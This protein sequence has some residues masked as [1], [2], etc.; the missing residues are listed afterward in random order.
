MKPKPEQSKFAKFSSAMQGL[1]AIDKKGNEVPKF[2]LFWHHKC[3]NE[4][5]VTDQNF[6]LIQRPKNN[7]L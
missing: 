5:D 7:Q 1:I 2:L 6:K 3:K 4:F